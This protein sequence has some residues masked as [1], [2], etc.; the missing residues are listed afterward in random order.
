M[1]IRS[2]LLGWWH[3]DVVELLVGEIERLDERVK[4][5]ESRL[6]PPAPPSEPPST[7]PAP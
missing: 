6:L 7:P 1:N 3:K 4:E 2:A 5:L